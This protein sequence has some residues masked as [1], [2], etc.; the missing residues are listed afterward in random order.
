[1]TWRPGS[2]FHTSRADWIAVIVLTLASVVASGLTVVFVEEAN[3]RLYVSLLPL[4][5]SLIIAVLS[6]WA[7]KALVEEAR[8]RAD[9]QAE[10][11]KLR[12]ELAVAQHAREFQHDLV[13]HL[14][15][16]STLIQIGAGDRAVKY[17]HRIL[18]S[19]QPGYVPTETASHALT[20]LLGMLGQKLTRA[21]T[22][23]ISLGVNLDTNWKESDVADEVA[24][25]VLGNLVDNALD[26][27]ANIGDGKPGRVELAVTIAADGTHFR[28][29]NNG[30][31]IPKRALQ[32]IFEAGETSKSG[33]HEGLGLYIVRRLVD[34]HNGTI[35]VTST[36]ATGTEFIVI[37][38]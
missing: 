17:L 1:M 10:L 12:S 37:F 22:E 26:A 20:L 36:P 34:Q 18:H 21:R 15:G 3:T 5:L 24:V 30:P 13:N 16:V 33:E 8:Q 23:G 4:A 38:S 9:E 32:K 25:R 14:T 7:G 28:V 6:V 31:V 27:A 2:S 29:W 11:W 35:Q 19:N